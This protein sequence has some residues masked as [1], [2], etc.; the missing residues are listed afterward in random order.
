MFAIT[1]FFITGFVLLISFLKFGGCLMC[2]QCGSTTDAS[3]CFTDVG[4]LVNASK[5]LRS[6]YH[7]AKNCTAS[8]PEWDRCMI[9][10]A[11][12]ANDKVSL[13]HRGC[14]DG[15]TFLADDP[16]FVHLK[17]NN[18]STCA[19]INEL[20]MVICYSFCMTDFCNGPQPEDKVPCNETGY[21]ETC[22]APGTP[23]DCLLYAFMMIIATHIV[24]CL[25]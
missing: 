22:G 7:Y 8:K 13:F 16:R 2:Y 5:G 24:Y 15:K 6:N 3:D 4:G 11:K 12:A 10:E 21:G 1:N 17:P 9:E 19:I 20:D 14:H 25:I 18:A 23:R